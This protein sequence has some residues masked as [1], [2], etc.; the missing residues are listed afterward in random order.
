[1]NESSGRKSYVAPSGKKLRTWK[2]AQQLMDEDADAEMQHDGV[3][4]CDWF[5]ETSA[6][7]ASAH[8]IC[9]CRN[10]VVASTQSAYVYFF[11]AVLC[12]TLYA[13]AAVLAGPVGGLYL[14]CDSH[15]RHCSDHPH[16]SFPL[17]HV[18]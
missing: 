18:N 7:H 14:N 2:E 6:Q 10:D 5:C 4:Q 15:R 9:A 3:F 13:R 17:A 1:M 12:E 11:V 16:A 8:S